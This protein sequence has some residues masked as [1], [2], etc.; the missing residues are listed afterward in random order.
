MEL[1]PNLAFIPKEKRI[2]KRLVCLIIIIAI[3]LNTMNI[4]KYP[5]TIPERNFFEPCVAYRISA[6]NENIVLTCLSL[7]RLKQMEPILFKT[8]S[9]TAMTTHYVT[10][11]LD[12]RDI[13]DKIS[14]GASSL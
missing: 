8:R 3:F 10:L 9:T 7:F 13:W 5:R 6:L 4:Y 1:K 12:I 2:Y 11:T 14:S